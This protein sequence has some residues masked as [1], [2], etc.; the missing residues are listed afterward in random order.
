MQDDIDHAIRSRRILTDRASALAPQVASDAF[1][2]Y[3]WLV[4][5]AARASVDA[6]TNL[7]IVPTGPLYQL[8]FEALVTQDP[9][10]GAEP[11]FLIEDR[12]VSYLSSASLLAVLRA[13]EAARR[14]PPYPVLAFANPA[15]AEPEPAT[16]DDGPS[17]LAKLQTNVLASYFGPRGFF[18]DL[19]GSESE[20]KA[21]VAALD[22]P[23][24]SRPLFEGEDASRER[25]LQLQAADCAK[26]PCLRDYR[27]LLFAT[28]AVLP[29]QVEGLVQPSLVLAHP[30][31]GEGFLTMADVLGLSLD[32]DVVSLS[33][34]NTGRGTVSHGDG[35]RGLT[36]AFM[37]AGTPVV[38]V[39]LWELSDLAASQLT[40]AFY[41][42]LRAGKSPA[43]ALRDAKLQ[44]LH[45]DDAILRFPYF[46]A[47]TVIFGDGAGGG[48]HG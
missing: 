36:Q 37:Y 24:D 11:H 42:G 22:A 15:Y 12:A 20:A 6:A 9:S 41:E 16:A 31:R 17:P 13:A 45:G 19:P 32:A 7:L 39:T 35:V 40:P 26:A 47:S 34:C 18:P 43:E 14:A 25:V 29:D 4:P 27:Y 44:L 3:T 1:A 10:T 28:H 23:A 30:E 2:L 5:P 33:A 46:W 38:S 21:V 8:A 48:P